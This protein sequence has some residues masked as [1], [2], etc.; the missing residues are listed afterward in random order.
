M[1]LRSSLSPLAPR[2]RSLLPGLLSLATI[3]SAQTLSRD[4]TVDFF[5]DTPSRNLT[6][7]AG[8]SDGRLVAGP[9]VTPLSGSLDADLLWTLHP[10]AKPNHF[11]VGSGP[12][13]RILKLTLA[14]DHKSFTAKTLATLPQPQV[15]A[16]LP[17]PDGRILA[18]T[19]PSAVI[20][21]LKPDTGEILAHAALPADSVFDLQLLPDGRVLAATGN[22]G[23]LYTID[24]ATFAKSPRSPA[25]PP[26]AATPAS[27]SPAATPAPAATQPG[28]VPA[29]AL[30]KAGITEFG[31]IRDRN[32]R[33]I[34]VLPDRVI[35][36]S[37]PSGN[38]YEFPLAGGTPI[39]LQDNDNAEV[40]DLLPDSAGG[41]YASLVF[42]GGATERR[43]NRNNATASG[44]SSGDSDSN[45]NAGSGAKDKVPDIFTA[46]RPAESFGGRSSLVW[47]PAGG[48]PETLASRTGIA[49]YQLARHHD[50]FLIGG[51]DNGDLLG[52]DPVS[53][54]SLTYAGVPGAQ[55]N[56]LA[57]VDS[58]G[59]AFLALANNAPGLTLID[60][61]AHAERTA[62]SRVIDIG[63][64]ARF[65]HIRFGRLRAIDASA[66]KLEM[67]A[68][69][70]RNEEE[71][72]TP[73]RPAPADDGGWLAPAGLAGR[74]FQLRV[75]LD[76][77]APA[78]LELDRATVPFLPQDRRPVLQSFRILSPDYAIVPRPESSGSLTH[79][80]GQIIGLSPGDDKRSSNATLLSSPVVPQPGAQIVYWT[81][82]DADDDNLAATFSIRPEN[83]DTWT[84]LAID[85]TDNYVQFDRSHLPD[86]LYFTRLVVTEQAP[87]A[88][89]DRLSVTFETDDLL[90][91]RTPPIIRSA[92]VRREG[93]H[94]VIELEGH[95]DLSLDSLVANFNNGLS[96][97][98]AQPV[99]G[100]LDGHTET[101]RLAT[102]P[103]TAAGATSVELILSD[104]SGNTSARRLPIL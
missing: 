86:G 55:L 50:Q 66:I 91:D 36:G 10:T 8:R 39:F 74:A 84:D 51:G 44:S 35:A 80:L 1:I 83:S 41:F 104:E 64:P 28:T 52:Y 90:V 100:I 43:I 87:R 34:L 22:P 62:L 97:D 79:T 78:D 92:S 76:A 17:L 57:P 15:L 26:P 14:G 6:G 95:D 23:I 98:S 25:P 63:Q 49:F 59:D 69:M 9:I 32:V 24:L 47:F 16:L 37:A 56:A 7:L 68:S 27:P 103:G 13:G 4:T 94:L 42:S 85:T 20:Y 99:D 53:R 29:E 65:G 93:D 48:F 5:R 60:F 2:L 58:T 61:S 102:E 77:S 40:T 101:F 75:T 31:R 70:G 21:L 19:S 45:G 88:P 73:W 89:A 81:V 33:R 71:G 30:A 72:W 38:I 18:G 82:D 96:L 11:L 67:R 54:R 3:A 46:A 12:S